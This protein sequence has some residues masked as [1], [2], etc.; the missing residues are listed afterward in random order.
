MSSTPSPAPAFSASPG[1]SAPL[2][3]DAWIPWVFVIAMAIVIA[4]NAVMVSFALGSWNGLVVD[5]SYERGLQYNQIL[6]AQ[7]Q[8]DALG[9]QVQARLPRGNH[10]QGCVGPSA[11]WSGSFRPA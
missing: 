6:A 1:L 8:Q 4:V 7:R 2:R 9:W 10:R 11:G 3:R 5:R